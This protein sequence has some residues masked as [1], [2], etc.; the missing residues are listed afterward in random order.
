MLVSQ[1]Y[2]N[3]GAIRLRNFDKQFHGSVELELVKSKYY[4]IVT[5]MLFAAEENYFC[6]YNA[7]YREM[8]EAIIHS[9]RQI[10][11]AESMEAIKGFIT[12]LLE[13]FFPENRNYVSQ[14]LTD[15]RSAVNNAVTKYN[16]ISE[17]NLIGLA[18]CVQIPANNRIINLLDPRCRDGIHLAVMKPRIPNSVSYGIEKDSN[19]AERAKGRVNHIAMGS[20]LGSRISNEAFDVAFMEPQ[21]S[22]RQSPYRPGEMSRPSSCRRKTGC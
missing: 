7:E 19:V 8:K 22:W 13:S 5:D 9:M 6:T 1:Y 18:N 4:S 11:T 17:T 12:S 3:D 16:P 20:F 21:I 10:E 14:T 2:L 15:F